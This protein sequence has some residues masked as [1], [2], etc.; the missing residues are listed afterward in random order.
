MVVRISLRESF[1]NLEYFITVINGRTKMLNSSN[2]HNKV[3]VR[4]FTSVANFIYLFIDKIANFI[5]F[6]CKN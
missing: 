1:Q 2:L 6:G 5:L 4:Y 3:W